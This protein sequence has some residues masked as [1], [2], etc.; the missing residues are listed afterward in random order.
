MSDERDLTQDTMADESDYAN[1]TSSCVLT[2][3]GKPDGCEI[4][5]KSTRR[6]MQDE[7]A[8][9]DDMEADSEEGDTE[10]D[11]IVVDD[12]EIDEDTKPL[13]NDTD[14]E[15]A[16]ALAAILS[17]EAEK[18]V[19]NL[20]S[21]VVGGRC[22]RAKPAQRLFPERELIKRAF[23]EDEKRELINEMRIWKKTLSAEAAERSVV[24]PD[25]K[26]SMS[27]EQVREKHEAVRVGLGLDDDD[28]ESTDTEED[29]DSSYEEDESEESDDESESDVESIEELD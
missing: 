12:T 17:E 19:G 26:M 13:P 22:L 21:K 24:F 28:D 18:F 8:E 23:E 4:P 6:A 2:S 27:L 1:A 10:N 3:L 9:D 25:L 11:S 15:G 7:D 14:E 5:T 29:E 20:E 16:R